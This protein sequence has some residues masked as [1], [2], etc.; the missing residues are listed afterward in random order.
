MKECPHDCPSRTATCRLT[1]ETG[2]RAELIRNIQKARRDSAKHREQIYH[3][4]TYEKALKREVR[5]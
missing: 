2:I 5:R 1:C 3:M 4:Y